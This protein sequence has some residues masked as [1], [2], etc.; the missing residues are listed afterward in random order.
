MLCVKTDSI[1]YVEKIIDV[2]LSVEYSM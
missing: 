1:E 2:V